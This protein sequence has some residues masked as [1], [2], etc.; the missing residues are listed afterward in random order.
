MSSKTVYLHL[1]KGR[2]WGNFAVVKM[3]KTRDAATRDGDVVLPL[4]IS[5][6][7]DFFDRAAISVHVE[8]MSG[9]G[10]VR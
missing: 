5:L 8:P 10:R 1:R 3:A 9:V 6:P 4:E 7:P 2:G